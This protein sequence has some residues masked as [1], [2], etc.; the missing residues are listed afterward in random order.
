MDTHTASL[1][2]SVPAKWIYRLIRNGKITATY[3]AASG[4]ADISTTDLTSA[5]A[6][7]LLPMKG[8]SGG[9]P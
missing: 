9:H 4:K 1:L 3:A 2:V 8:L 5:N 6:A 7:T